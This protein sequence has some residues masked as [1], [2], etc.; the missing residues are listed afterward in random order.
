[1]SGLGAEVAKNLML[2]GLKSLTIMDNCT[3]TQEDFSSQFLLPSD[4]LGENVSIMAWTFAFNLVDYNIFLFSAS[5][6]IQAANSSA[7][8]YGESHCFAGGA[9]IQGRQFLQSF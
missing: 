9:G 7:E 6:G 4:N 8:Y 2:S 5:R 1:M 3:V